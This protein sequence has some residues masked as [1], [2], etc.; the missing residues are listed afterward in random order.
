MQLRRLTD[1]F[2]VCRLSPKSALPAYSSDGFFS[3]TRTSEEVSV[4][5][6]EQDAPPDCVQERGWRG[7]QV[8]GPIPFT[9][10]GV[11]HSLTAPIAQAGISLFA[12]STYDTDYL[13]VKVQDFERAIQV[14][15]AAG[16]EIEE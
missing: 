8:V 15:K 7:I 12:I 2:S 1:V 4:V 16:H 5:C 14:L 13:L 9:M 3:L 6:R 11:L 10:V